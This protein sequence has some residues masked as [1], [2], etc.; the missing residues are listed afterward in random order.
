MANELIKG[1]VKCEYH[2][3]MFDWEYLVKFPGSTERG[4]GLDVRNGTLT[5]GGWYFVMKESVIPKDE[6]SG[7]LSITIATK[8]EKDCSFLIASPGGEF[9]CIPNEEIIFLDK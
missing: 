9:F 2:K 4:T 8:R 1:Y 7:L 5:M 3:G 6:K